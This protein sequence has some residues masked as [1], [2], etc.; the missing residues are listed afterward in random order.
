MI[1]AVSDRSMSKPK[2]KETARLVDLHWNEIEAAEHEL[3][4]R[5]TLD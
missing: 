5:R 3:R 2:S 4:K 1:I